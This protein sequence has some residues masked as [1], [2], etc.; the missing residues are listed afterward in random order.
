ML[1]M[2]PAGVLL[3]SGWPPTL[4]SQ[5]NLDWGLPLWPCTQVT[6]EQSHTSLS[7][8]ICFRVDAFSPTDKATSS[9]QHS[10]RNL[11]I[12]LDHS[13]SLTTIIPLNLIVLQNLPISSPFHGCNLSST[14]MDLPCSPS[15]SKHPPEDPS[16][17]CSWYLLGQ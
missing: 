8:S 17:G 10:A 1:P 6:P 5:P 7:S 9:S 3:Q 4:T 14:R 11:R 16:I 15:W 12:I 13:L 2:S